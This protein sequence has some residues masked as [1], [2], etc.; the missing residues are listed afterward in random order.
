MQPNLLAL[1][2]QGKAVQ[3]GGVGAAGA[4]A[5]GREGGQLEGP[6]IKHDLCGNRSWNGPHKVCGE[7]G[8]LR[9]RH[10]ERAPPTAAESKGREAGRRPSPFGQRLLVHQLECTPLLQ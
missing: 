6:P 3:V 5:A 8:M 10:R 4:Y 7:A 2:L 9:Q 1:V